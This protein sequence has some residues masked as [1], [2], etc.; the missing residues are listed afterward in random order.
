MK[1]FKQTI[2]NGHEWQPCIHCGKRFVIGEIITALSDDE[3]NS[4]GY[5]YCSECFDRFW[6]CPLPAPV[7]RDDD[8]YMVAIED[9]KLRVYP[10]PMSPAEYLVRKTVSGFSEII[11]R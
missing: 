5:W 11:R 10:K 2:A 7:E 1:I 8:F 9:G 4:C 6:F 3:G